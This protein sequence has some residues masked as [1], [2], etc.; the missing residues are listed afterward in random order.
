M[1]EHSWLM[2]IYENPGFASW[3]I[4]RHIYLWNGDDDMADLT[5]RIS[6]PHVDVLGEDEGNR[7]YYRLSSMIRLLSAIRVLNGHDKIHSFGDL[8]L[9]FY[10]QNRYKRPSYY[11]KDVDIEFEELMNPF[12]DTIA[13]QVEEQAVGQPSNRSED[14]VRLA[15]LD[16]LVRENLLLLSL[17]EEQILYLLINTY[18]IF[19]NILNELDLGKSQGKIVKRNG[20]EISEELHSA[21]VSL[22]KH[23]G[24]INTKKGGAGFLSRHGQTKDRAPKEIPTIQDVRH[25]LI[26][27]MNNWLD[28]K[29]N[30]YFGK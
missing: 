26:D 2:M 4:G 20:P 27:V 15:V 5:P 28:F 11:S 16:P 10:N 14:I 7:A 6:S 21:L 24:F 18:K 12:D 1:S 25:S 13:K 30:E 19:E 23:T 3:N 8:G 9:Y 17:G 29:R 22:L